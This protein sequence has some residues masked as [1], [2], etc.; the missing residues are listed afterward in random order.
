M[1]LYALGTAACAFAPNIWALMAFRLVASLGIGGE[2]AAGAS[3]VAEVV[4][5]EERVKAGAWLYTAAPAG[6][7]LATFVN[8]Q[9][10]GV[11]LPDNP[12]VSWRYVFLFGLVP[13]AI[14][15]VIRS[16][17]KEPERWEAHQDAATRTAWGEIFGPE[18]RRRTLVGMG[19]AM[20]ALLTWWSCN[21]FVPTV[22]TM[23]A[24][25]AAEAR[26]LDTSA[27]LALVEAWKLDATLWF[28]A[29]GFIGTLL[30]IPAA[31]LLG[32]K[33]MFILYFAASAAA[34]LTAFGLDMPAETRLMM[35]FV[36][37]LSVFGIIGGF[38]FYLPELFPTRLR[39]TASGFC[40]NIGRIVAAAGPFLVGYA[41][42]TGIAMQAL[43]VVGFVP[44]LA[45]LLS[46]LVIE[47]RGQRLLD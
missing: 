44:L 31:T 32:R 16:F 21:A 13:A 10:A 30:T 25:D 14:A 11:W 41:A 8:F 27:T 22:A 1:L 24:Q 36:I 17:V 47:T 29:G 46:P 6:L 3:M 38:S 20:I 40:F 37:G 42:S 9:V 43:F 34:I 5:E 28:N 2:W 39:A 19:L 26:G 33:P 12:E 35:Y 7:L 4:P 23:L 45:L 15:F 18:Y